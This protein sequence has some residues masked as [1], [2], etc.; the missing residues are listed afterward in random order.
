MYNDEEHIVGIPSGRVGEGCADA[1]RGWR[2]RRRVD[3][4]RSKDR[5]GKDVQDGLEVASGS[6]LGFYLLFLFTN[7][8]HLF[9]V[10]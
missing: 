9:Y 10:F 8:S 1:R 7:I 2:S 4:E 5:E 6:S 3:L